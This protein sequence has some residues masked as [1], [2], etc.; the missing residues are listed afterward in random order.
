VARNRQ[1]E[2]F[3]AS[4]PICESVI[5]R[6]RTLSCPS[7]DVKVLNMHDDA[8]AAR[9]QELGVSSVPAVAIDGILVDCCVGRGVDEKA[10]QAAGLG[11]PI[12]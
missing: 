5:S 8:A 7:C 1:I 4:C 2:I 11:Q 3:S 12:A 10:L 9:A 6:V